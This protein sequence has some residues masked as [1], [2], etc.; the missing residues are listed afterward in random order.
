MLL[1]RSTLVLV[2]LLLVV[3]TLAPVRAQEDNAVPPGADIIQAVL[4]DAS[5]VSN[6]QLSVGNLH[7]QFL[8]FKTV[9]LDCPTGSERPVPARLYGYG[10]TVSWGAGKNLDYR[11][12]ALADRGGPGRRF[13]IRGLRQRTR[14]AS[15]RLRQA[16]H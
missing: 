8:T 13:S 10:I 1:K 4:Q 9:S 11:A 15:R 3:V 12:R 6:Q 5:R 2:V 16:G 14:P 7:W